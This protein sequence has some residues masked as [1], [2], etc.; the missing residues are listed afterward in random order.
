MGAL[1]TWLLF[2]GGRRGGGRWE[3]ICLGFVIGYF[4]WFGYL[5]LGFVGFLIGDRG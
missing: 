4:V 1:G 5:F 2:S 3:G